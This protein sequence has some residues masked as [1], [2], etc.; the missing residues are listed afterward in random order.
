MTQQPEEVRLPLPHIELAG[1]FYGPKQGRP[2]I[3][4]HGW[5]DN[6]ASFSRLAPKL[7]GMRILALDLAGHGHSEHRPQGAP[8]ALWDY[9]HDV[10]QV[11]EYLGWPRFSLLGHS[12]GAMIAVMLAASMP[13]RVERLALIDG[14]LPLTAP[15]QASVINLARSL[16]AQLAL[17]GKRKPIYRSV[18]RA[19]TV[20]QRGFVA[21]S[22]VAA[23]YLVRRGLMRVP[24]GY[25]WRSDSRLSLPSPIRLTQ[26]QATAFVC[27]LQCPVRLLLAEQ[28]LLIQHGELE[29]LLAKTQIEVQQL[30]G[31]H[32][33]HLDDELGAQRVAACINPFLNA[34]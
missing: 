7:T 8:Y 4:L 9:L 24:G 25:S 34:S 31:G 32:H 18:Q 15:A 12:L 19:I 26:E 30:P 1:R 23:E 27:S 28:G 10:L 5:L 17:P 14:L 13:R 29:A 20:R 6:A 2:L 33:L 16:E 22:Q 21:V 11:A 3:A